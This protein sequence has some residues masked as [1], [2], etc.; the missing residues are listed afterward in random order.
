MRSEQMTSNRHCIVELNS[1]SLVRGRLPILD[2]ISL[3]IAEGEAVA[4]MGPNG[5]GKS[6][7][8]KCLAGALRSTNGHVRCFGNSTSRSSIVQQRIG[9][10]GHETGLYSELNVLENLVFAGRMYGVDCP[11][12]RA[13]TL[14]GETRL[15]SLAHRLVAQLSQG[16][17][18]RVAI[19]RALVH[20]PQLLLLDEPFASLDVEGN[21]WLERCFESWRIAKRTVCFATHDV[22][23]SRRLADRLVWLDAG[24]IVDIESPFKLPASSQK[25]A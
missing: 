21:Q 19:T 1:L 6:T 24:R 9:F 8:L 3:T 22:E 5:A 14:L 16:M 17:Q 23:Q 2:E 12:E 15:E 25:S 20:D 13:E 18:R 4:F 10:I 11:I 7:L